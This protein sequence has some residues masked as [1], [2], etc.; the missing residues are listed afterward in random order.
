MGSVA[1][2]HKNKPFLRRRYYKGTQQ[3]TGRPRALRVSVGG[4]LDFIPWGAD[5]VAY[6]AYAPT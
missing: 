6:S 2:A 4:A 5:S 3:T 1:R